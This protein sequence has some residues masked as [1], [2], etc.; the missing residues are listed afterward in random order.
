MNKACFEISGQALCYVLVIPRKIGSKKNKVLDVPSWT[1]GRPSAMNF[2][3]LSTAEYL[4]GR[5]ADE[6]VFQP[7]ILFSKHP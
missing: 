4:L 7:S 5:L 1:V 3:F 2:T 6:V